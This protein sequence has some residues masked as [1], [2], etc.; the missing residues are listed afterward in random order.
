M[1]FPIAALLFVISAFIFFVIYAVGSR[2]I[3]FVVNALS[4]TAPAEALATM[5]VIQTAFG[6]LAAIFFIV[7]IVLIFVLDSLAD[8]PEKYWRE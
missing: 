6:I 2:L 7:G 3:S 1:R 4:P 5:T 8:E